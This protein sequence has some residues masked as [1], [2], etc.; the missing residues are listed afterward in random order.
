[1]AYLLRETFEPSQDLAMLA[2]RILHDDDLKARQHEFR[3]NLV[4]LDKRV[5][6]ARGRSVELQH[7]PEQ[8]LEVGFL[9]TGSQE[10]QRALA[11]NLGKGTSKVKIAVGDPAILFVTNDDL[12]LKL[13]RMLALRSDVGP[14]VEVGHVMQVALKS[15]VSTRWQSSAP[16]PTTA[17]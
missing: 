16:R 7:L 13:R 11:E 17:S 12:S 10:Q 15:E 1:V 5:V 2:L 9:E 14:Q 6:W 3:I 4:L 8:L